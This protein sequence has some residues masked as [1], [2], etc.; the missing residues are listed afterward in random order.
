[1]G[2]LPIEDHGIVGDLHTAALVGKDGTIDWLCL[3]AF[4]S[5]SVFCSILDDEKGGHFSLRPMDYTRSQQLYLPDTNVLLTRFLA[6]QGMAEILDFMPI[7]E[8]PGSRHRLVRNVRVVRGRM[9]FEV[10]CRPAFDYARKEHFTSVGRTGAVFA[11]R[12]SSH[13]SL[14]LSTEVPLQERP[15]GGAGARF[16][17]SEGE[18]ATF[19]LAEIE[20]GEGPGEVLSGWDFE[21]LLRSTL[22]FWRRWLSKS[23]YRGRWREEVHRSALVLKLMVYDPTGALVAAPTMG[24]PERIGG[25]RNW[26][27]R[28]TWL[29]DAAFTLYALLSIGFDEEARNFMGYLRARCECDWDGL[30]QPLY[31]IDG[32][33]IIAETE[34]DHLSGY[35]N[36]RP[37]RLGNA[38]YCQVQLDLYGAILDAAYL[39]NKHG[40]PLDHDLWQN[41]RRILAW[42]SE[43]WQNPDEGI[44]EVRGG[45]RQFVSSK[46]MSWVALERAGRIARQR[47]LPAGDGRWMSE[48]DRIYEE[49]IEKGWNPEKKSFVQ[50]Y[51]SDALDASLLLMPLTKFVG[52]TDPRWLSTLEQIQRELTYDTLVD[53]YKTNEAAPDGLSGDEGSFSLCSFWLVECL[54][55][56]G[57]LEEAR[58]A[59]EKMFSYA[60]HL[61]LYA[62][63]IGPGGEALGNFPQALTHLSLIS[64]AVH[65]DR[66]LGAA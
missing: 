36:S 31:G 43:N 61:G 59:L 13:A 18:R 65:L 38:A 66:D 21:E 57:R 20:E 46:V 28:Y 6:P 4:D 17:L 44:W 56:A 54:T 29:R 15:G 2:Y 40:A 3:P 49:I 12:G 30:L 27:Y 32:R 52:P 11:S 51:G 53:R 9:T 26:D 25:E 33:E 7:L 50:H 24:L 62:E 16:T 5:P 42:L 14:G 19:V 37:V 55:R 22:D 58:L 10:E 48:R 47:G 23:T 35:M 63:E 34:L 45:K 8:G 39:Y 64:A 60:N 41:L 1:L